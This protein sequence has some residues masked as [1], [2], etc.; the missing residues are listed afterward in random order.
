MKRIVVGVSGASGACFG[1]CVLQLL[2][3]HGGA[4]THLILTDAARRTIRHELDVDAGV[5]ARFAHRT[6][7]IDDIG[8]VT[9]S[10]SFRAD[11][12]IIAPCSIRTL[13]AVAY[14]QS[15]NLLIRSAD[16]VLKERRPLVLMV[17][18]SPLHLGH[19]RAMTAAAEIG[20]VIAPPVP[21]M[22]TRPRSLDEMVTQTAARC[23]GLIG[24]DCDA[25]VRWGDASLEQRA[26]P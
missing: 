4:E 19:L 5:L 13:S 17:R 12:M 6:H 16:V 2:Q 18:E 8:A 10:G 20:A 23:L 26:E 11:A 24:I 14:G 3:R 21:A 22:Y 7:A 15:A 25:M 1:L 9:A